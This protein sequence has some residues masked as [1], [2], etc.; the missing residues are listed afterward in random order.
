MQKFLL[1]LFIILNITVPGLLIGQETVKF[2]ISFSTDNSKAFTALYFGADKTATP[3]LDT[4]LGEKDLP[5][6]KPPGDPHGWFIFFDSTLNYNVV[7]YVDMRPFPGINPVVYQL[8]VQNIV[9]YINFSWKPVISP[10]I[11]SIF[12][13]DNF[14]ELDIVRENMATTN[15]Y[16]HDTW[17]SDIDK[18]FIKVWYKTGITNVEEDKG[19]VNGLIAYKDETIIFDTGIIEYRI[20]SLDGTV[21][22]DG[23]GN[24]SEKYLNI[25]Y[26]PAGIYFIEAKAISGKILHEKILKY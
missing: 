22:N 8:E 26:Y 7:S 20:L 25:G 19:T 1:K 24:G 4:L 21:L 9:R 3:G 10:L 6:V 23:T 5:N 16:T 12:L 18:Y 11:D 15:S 14:E 2:N 13:E 17:K